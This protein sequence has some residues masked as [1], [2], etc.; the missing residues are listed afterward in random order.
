MRS[1]APRSS[2]TAPRAS[3]SC[4]VGSLLPGHMGSGVLFAR[5]S[6]APPQ[7]RPYL[8]T[9][10]SHVGWASISTHLSLLLNCHRLSSIPAPP[11]EWAATPPERPRPSPINLLSSVESRPQPSFPLGH[12]LNFCLGPAPKQTPNH[13][14]WGSARGP[15]PCPTPGP[16]VSADAARS[17]YGAQRSVFGGR[18]LSLA[19]G[20]VPWPRIDFL[21]SGGSS[22]SLWIHFAV[23]RRQ[24]LCPRCDLFCFCCCLYVRVRDLDQGARQRS[25]GVALRPGRCWEPG[26]IA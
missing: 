12:W 24:Q 20:P 22:F 18:A 26:D 9:T 25:H 11:F 8:A 21:S 17:S 1:C 15:A 19:G 7:P 13:H 16:I 2:H 6:S 4:E 3:S 14:W 5:F 10:P 23:P